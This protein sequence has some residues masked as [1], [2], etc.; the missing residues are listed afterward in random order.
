MA[1]DGV[2]QDGDSVESFIASRDKSLEDMIVLKKATGDSVFNVYRDKA[3][4]GK[5]ITDQFLNKR[6]T[7]KT[8]FKGFSITDVDRSNVGVL[9]QCRGLQTIAILSKFGVDMKPYEGAIQSVIENIFW[10]IDDEKE[11]FIFDATPYLKQNLDEMETDQA[12]VK[13]YVETIATIITALMAT[14]TMLHNQIDNGGIPLN[15]THKGNSD[16]IGEIEGVIHECIRRLNMSALKRDASIEF[17]IEGTVIKDVYGR[18]CEYRGWNFTK[19][20]DE[21][22]AKA[23]EPSIY[24]TYVVTLAYMSIFE[25]LKDPIEV[26]RYINRKSRKDATMEQRISLLS[27]NEKYRRNKIFFDKIADDF[28]EF[29]KC[30]VDAGHTIDLKI[31]N[32]DISEV[33]LGPEL[34]PVFFKEIQNSTTN[35]AFFNVLMTIGI[36]INTGVDI[37]YVAHSTAKYNDTSKFDE[38]YERLQYALQNV[39]RCYKTMA[40]DG[41]EYVVNEYVLNFN[42]KIPQSLQDQAK[43]LRSQKISMINLMPTIIK[44]YNLISNYLIRYPQRQAVT[45]LRHIMENRSEDA[46]GS[47]K[48]EWDKDGYNVNSNYFYIEALKSFYEYYSTYEQKYSADS[49][50]IFDALKSEYEKNL[51]EREKLYQEKIEALNRKNTELENITNPLISEIEKMIMEKMSDAFESNFTDMLKQVYKSNMGVD[52]EREGVSVLLFDVLLSN[53]PEKIFESGKKVNDGTK[54]VLSKSM[55]KFKETVELYLTQE[56]SLED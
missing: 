35:D 54:G 10:Q 28:N 12:F 37:D 18:N 9:T 55:N 25:E 32:H 34:N 13:D 5:K 39:E 56:Y 49:Q 24:F 40:K 20:K 38:Y 29:N 7:S 23:M 26:T 8:K 50:K 15:I 1:T 51:N 4:I 30:C 41:R 44:T 52:S 33:F 36:L 2:N 43:L 19:C 21:K 6:F 46:N 14:R 42:E 17:E 31:R 53:F 47:K 45:Y 22:E 11:G 16:I 3:E 27:V 48:W